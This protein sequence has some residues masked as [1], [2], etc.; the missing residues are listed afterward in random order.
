[1]YANQAPADVDKYMFSFGTI[2]DNRFI[3]AQ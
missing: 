3:D 2:I 1:M